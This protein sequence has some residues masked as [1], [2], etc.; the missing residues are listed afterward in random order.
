MKF[1]KYI[2]IPILI[3]IFLFKIIKPFKNESASKTIS[4]ADKTQALA[5]VKAVEDYCSLEMVKGRPIPDR[6]T[7]PDEVLFDGEAPRIMDMTLTNDCRAKGT[8]TYKTTTYE[9]NYKTEK[10]TIK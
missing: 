5:F 10:L 7:N 6:I 3:I 4:K 2:L 8:F 1:N 9:Y